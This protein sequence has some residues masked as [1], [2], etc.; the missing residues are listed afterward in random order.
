MRYSPPEGRIREMRRIGRYVLMAM[1]LIG[2]SA[3]W[4]TYAIAQYDFDPPSSHD[5][6]LGD[7]DQFTALHPNGFLTPDLSGC[8]GCHGQNLEGAAG[9]SCYLCHGARWNRRLEQYPDSHTDREHRAMHAR[10][11][12]RPF[13]SGCTL[14]H[15]PGLRGGIALSCY[16]CHG[17]KWRKRGSGGYDDRHHHDHDSD[18]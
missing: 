6:E 4:G 11:K 18:D 15:G 16:T 10:G 7:L 9:P 13:S 17:R 8:T 5:V 2:L 3:G 12:N 14:C 1:T